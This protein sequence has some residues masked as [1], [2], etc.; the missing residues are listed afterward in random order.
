M[1]THSKTRHA[2]EASYSPSHF[3]WQL[4]TISDTD[5]LSLS[6]GLPEQG[7]TESDE[8]NARETE[9]SDSGLAEEEHK[10]EEAEEKAESFAG[11]DSS[12]N[13]TNGNDGTPE[14]SGSTGVVRENLS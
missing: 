4:T 6:G 13:D 9:S 1:G 12:S 10:E 7:V 3:Q 8:P 5:D 2:E 14:N 11:E